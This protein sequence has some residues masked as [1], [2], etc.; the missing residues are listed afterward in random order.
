MNK[1]QEFVENKVKEARSKDNLPF[2][3]RLDCGLV[4][5]LNALEWQGKKC[6]GYFNGMLIE[7]FLSDYKDFCDWRGSKDFLGQ[8]PETQLEIAKLLGYKEV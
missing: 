4:G 7:M 8:T 3:N 5:I 2:D 6:I 1:I